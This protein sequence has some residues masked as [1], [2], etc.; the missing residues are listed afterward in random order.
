M[1]DQS[2]FDRSAYTVAKE[3]LLS[4]EQVTPEMLERYLSVPNSQRPDSLAHV[5]RQLLESAHSPGMMP[6]VI[7]AAMGG[8]GSLEAVLCHF[9]SLAIVEKYGLDWSALL[10]EI[11]S[12]VNPQGQ[13]R[14][15]PRSLWP[16]FCRTAL[17]GAAFL[18]QFDELEDFQRWVEP[19]NQDDRTR[20]A[21][22]LLLSAEIDGIG[23]PLA[24]DFLKEL[25]Y[26]GYC[27]PDVHLKVIFPQLGLS[28]DETD[29]GVFKAIVR[30]ARNVGVTPYA[31]DKLFWLTGSG[32][33][34]LDGVR[35]GRIRDEFVRYAQQRLGC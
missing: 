33:F 2:Q 14:R 29:F 9:Q 17:S 16:R 27:K 23:F 1:P 15:S 31:V 24:C 5:Y 21:L 4:F 6:S 8:V 7:G 12:E 28:S 10:D 19:F 25:G 18:T 30:V 32:N 22:P 20:P 11:V 13:I 35:I 26:L 34:Y 3:Y